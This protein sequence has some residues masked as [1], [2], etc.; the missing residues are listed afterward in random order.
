MDRLRRRLGVVLAGALREARR[1]G[2]DGR[3]AAR[4]GR[5]CRR[6]RDRALGHVPAQAR[7]H[8]VRARRSRPH[9]EARGL[10]LRLRRLGLRLP[11]AADRAQRAVGGVPPDAA[12]SHGRALPR[13]CLALRDAPSRARGAAGAPRLE[14]A[15]HRWR[16]GD[17]VE[18][19]RGRLRSRPRE[20]RE[21]EPHLARGRGRRLATAARAASPVRGE[22]PRARDSA[23]SHRDHDRLPDR[24]R[25]GRARRARAEVAV[26][27]RREVAHA[28]GEAGCEGARARTRLVVGLGAAQRA[29]ERSGQDVRGL[30]LAVGA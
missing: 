18:V 21:R 24:R 1:R 27:Q 22:A 30:R 19:G 3:P 7:R 17:L 10:A 9:G 4:S 5:A 12:H 15:V 8:A 6:S 26:V 11:N 16:R 25:S 20:L 13:E 29:L 28:R 23:R 2:C 14:R